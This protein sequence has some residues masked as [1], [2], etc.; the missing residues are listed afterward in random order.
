ML[1][2]LLLQRVLLIMLRPPV[3]GLTVAKRHMGDQNRT[4]Y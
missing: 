2:L 1:L 4:E 3:A